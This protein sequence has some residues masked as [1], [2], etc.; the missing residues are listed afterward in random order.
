MT[1]DEKVLPRTRKFNPVGFCL[2][3][4]RVWQWSSSFFVW[5]SFSLLYDHIQRNGLGENNQMKGVQLLVRVH[6]FLSKPRRTPC[7]LA[8]PLIE[9]YIC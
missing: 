8:L 3:G 5:A 4:I 1:M 6:P 2:T 7:R 9:P